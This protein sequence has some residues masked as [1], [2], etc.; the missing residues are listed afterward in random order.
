LQEQNI[1]V[2]SDQIKRFSTLFRGLDRAHGVWYPH[3]GSVETVQDS[4]TDDIFKKHLEGEV[5]LGI[6]MLMENGKC[7]FGVIDIDYHSED[8]EADFASL[9]Y[10]IDVLELPLVLCRSK[11]GG[12]HLYLFCSNAQPAKAIIN[13]LKSWAGQLGFSKSEIFPKQIKIGPGETGNWINLPYFNYI[14]TVRY[15]IKAGEKMGLNTFL[16][17]AES[18]IQDSLTDN[19]AT[20]DDESN[21]SQQAPPCLLH[22]MTAGVEEGSRNETMFNF[23]I[24]YKRKFPESFADKMLALNFTKFDPPLVKSEIDILIKQV[25]KDKEYNYKCNVEPLVSYCDRNTCLNRKYGIK[26]HS[27]IGTEINIGELKKIKS[28]PPRWVLMINNKEVEVSTGEIMSWDLLRQ[29][30]MER[31]DMVAPAMKKED[32][33]VILRDRMETKIDIEAPDDAS[34]GGQIGVR[35]VEFTA[36]GISLNLEN[37]KINTGDKKSIVRGIPTVLYAQFEDNFVKNGQEPKLVNIN[38][39]YE[40]DPFVFFRGGDFV[41]FLKRRKSEEVKGEKLWS[42][43]RRMGCGHIKMRIGKGVY[44]V[45]YKPAELL[46]VEDFDNPVDKQEEEF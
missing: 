19:N 22:L 12:A 20:K 4:V 34:I 30:I 18:K 33:L 16:S 32:W 40:G 6:P 13:K 38:D 45:W 2:T 14:D 21:D 11:R 23:G 8:S 3:N 28:L 36:R 46:L 5:G 43:I 31:V 44:Q 10:K 1:T 17:Y 35:L 39:N 27:G 37:N 25:Q 9:E 24:Y 41:E 42:V 29:A 7:F 26:S 15:G